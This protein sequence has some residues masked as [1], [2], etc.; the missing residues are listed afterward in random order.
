MDYGCLIKFVKFYY[1]KYKNKSKSLKKAVELGDNA[2]YVGNTC[3]HNSVFIINVFEENNKL[4]NVNASVTTLAK[5]TDVS[6][7]KKYKKV[8]DL[9]SLCTLSKAYCSESVLKYKEKI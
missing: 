7:F 8:N 5:Q 9:L 2:R 3:A 1:S 4:K 6:K